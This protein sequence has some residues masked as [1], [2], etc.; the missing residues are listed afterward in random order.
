[1]INFRSNKLIKL[2]R[3]H[4]AI[5]RC[6]Y[7]GNKFQ[8]VIIKYQNQKYIESFPHTRVLKHFSLDICS[9]KWRP[10]FSVKSAYYFPSRNFIFKAFLNFYLPSIS[11]SYATVFPGGNFMNWYPKKKYCCYLSVWLANFI[12]KSLRFFFSTFFCCW[13]FSLDSIA[14][15]HSFL[16]MLYSS[17]VTSRQKM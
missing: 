1:M 17:W 9:S 10:A 16:K 2:N 8:H 4:F 15:L 11:S 5:F 7:N 12:P 3:Y 14:M 6:L 13:P